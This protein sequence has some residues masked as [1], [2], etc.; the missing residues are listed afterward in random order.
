V[1][2][3][4]IRYIRVWDDKFWAWDNK[5]WQGVGKESPLDKPYAENFIKYFDKLY[6]DM[7]GYEGGMNAV[8]CALTTIK[9]DRLLFGTDYYPN[10]T[11]SPNGSKDAADCRKYI[12]DVKA[13]DLPLKTINDILSGTA[14][15]LLKI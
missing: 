7:A 6:F 10:F 1:R 11:G 3:R 9:P 12:E 14:R 13:L 2:E 8:N 4:L 5:Y 15:K